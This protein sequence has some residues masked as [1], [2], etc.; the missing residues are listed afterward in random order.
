MAHSSEKI[1]IGLIYYGIGTLN[2]ICFIRKTHHVLPEM[3][4]EFSLLRRIHRQK[5]L[6][7][8]RDVK[9]NINEKTTFV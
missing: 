2:V 6:V 1:S 8:I 3:N 5:L 7:K 4:N 9:H